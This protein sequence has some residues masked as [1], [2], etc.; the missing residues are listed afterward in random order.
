[1][2]FLDVLIRLKTAY[3]EPDDR[4]FQLVNFSATVN[5]FFLFSMQTRIYLSPI[6]SDDFAEKHIVK[7]HYVFSQSNAPTQIN[8]LLIKV[9]GRD[10]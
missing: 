5:L 10:R 2:L 6:S 1:M 7:L 4:I 8:V 9:S 3:S